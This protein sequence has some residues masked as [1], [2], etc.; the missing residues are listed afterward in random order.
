[1]VT[2]EELA[3]AEQELSEVEAQLLNLSDRKRLLL[4]R[5][6]Q[7]KDA[8]L[9]K[10]NHLLTSR[11]WSNTGMAAILINLIALQCDT[12]NF[13]FFKASTTLGDFVWFKFTNQ[14]AG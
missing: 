1:M 10:K 14:L 9:L 2:E 11:D 13:S 4:D 3:A 6:G 8:I 5:I 7:L 12:H